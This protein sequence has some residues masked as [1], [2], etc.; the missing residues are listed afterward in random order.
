[1]DAWMHGCDSPGTYKDDGSNND[2][3]SDLESIRHAFANFRDH[4]LMAWLG[5]STVNDLACSTYCKLMAQGEGEC[6]SRNRVW[7]RFW[8]Q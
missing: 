4:S 2:S 5:P 6:L 8:T 3:A 7:F 1:M